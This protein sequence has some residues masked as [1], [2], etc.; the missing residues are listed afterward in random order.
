[1]AVHTEKYESASLFKDEVPLW[2]RSDRSAVSSDTSDSLISMWFAAAGSPII[3]AAGWKRLLH[4]QGFEHATAAGESLERP[5]LLSRQAVVLGISNGSI[6]IA[7]ALGTPHGA[8]K[9]GLPHPRVQAQK[10]FSSPGAQ[11]Q[12][13]RN[14]QHALHTVKWLPVSV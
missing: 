11:V 12:P 2:V 3:S 14:P 5:P 13:R 10:G 8:A 6:Q 1:M 4:E 7:R 9:V